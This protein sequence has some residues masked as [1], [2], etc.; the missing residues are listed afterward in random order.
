MSAFIKSL[1][2]YTP[3]QFGQNGHA[4][5]GW[6][7]NIQERIAQL[8]MQLIR[9]GRNTVE[10]LGDIFDNIIQDI[11]SQYNSDKISKEQMVD[12]LSVMYKMV[13]FTRDI[14]DGKGEYT[15]SYMLIYRLYAFYPELS[16][17]ALKCCVVAEPDIHPFGSW[18]DIKYFCNYCKVQS[19]EDH[20]L[21]F[22]A[23]QLVNEQIRCDIQNDSDKITLA[24]KWVP[25]EKSVKFGWLY[26]KLACDYFNEYISSAK[27]D[28][29]L[30]AATLKCFTKYRDICSQLNK[31]LDTVQIKQCGNSWATIDPAKQTSITMHKQ[32][33]AFLNKT[34]ENAQRSDKEDRIQCANNFIEFINNVCNGEATVKGKRVSLPDFTKEAMRSLEGTNETFLLNAQWRDN[35]SQTGALGDM[36]A[37]VDVSGSMEGE[38]LYAAIALGCRIAEKSRLGKRVLTFSAQPSWVNLE[39]CREFTDMVYKLK[40]AEWGQNTDIY[41]AFALILNAIEQANLN[42]EQVKQMVFVILSDMQMDCSDINANSSRN[43]DTL[44]NSIAELYAKKGIEMT[45]APFEPPHLVFWNLSS[46][47]GAPVL[48]TMKNVSTMSGFSPALLNLYCEKGIEALQSVTPW[49]M[50]LEAL[51]NKR[52]DVLK[53]KL[54]EVLL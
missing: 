22:Y 53:E 5:Y 39:D 28:K 23:V 13:G 38:P 18:K 48:S 14:I 46:R 15:L 35:S 10:A 40:G 8:H 21:I 9:T 4:E 49:L 2:N 27:T 47:T 24:G 51:S 6:S 45:G 30:K 25:R 11:Q 16:K 41:K 3:I 12:M 32:K 50:L 54:V 19:C 34:S 20:P 44:F 26:K 17:F 43:R 42:A 36:I 29:Q 31:R 1:D 37:M 7:N 33:K 52:Y